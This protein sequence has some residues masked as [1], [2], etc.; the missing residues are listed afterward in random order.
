MGRNTYSGSHSK[1]MLTEDGTTWGG[2][3]D[4]AAENPS[5]A[6]RRKQ[7]SRLPSK[8]EIRK[9]A[10]EDDKGEQKLARSFISQCAT[11]HVSAQLNAS[12]PSPPKPLRPWIT[13]WG[14]NVLWAP[15]IIAPWSLAVKSDSRIARDL[16]AEAFDGSVRFLRCGQSA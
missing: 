9:Q 8:D 10:E 1:I 5:P 12:F 3:E 11:A 4:S 6:S 2:S 15:R 16:A 14:G 13:K 7:D